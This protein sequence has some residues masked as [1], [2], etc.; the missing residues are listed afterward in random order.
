MNQDNFNIDE[1]LQQS[2]KDFA[3]E[4]PD[5]WQGIEQG[6]SQATASASSVAIQ[7]QSLFLKVMATAFATSIVSSVLFLAIKTDPYRQPLPI[8]D[9][10]KND[11]ATQV[12][13]Y[14]TIAPSAEINI[15]S[16]VETTL[17]KDFTQIVESE[18]QKINTENQNQKAQTIK[19]TESFHNHESNISQEQTLNSES[20]NKQEYIQP[21]KSSAKQDNKTHNTTTHTKQELIEEKRNSAH[22]QQNAAITEDPIFIPNVITP[23]GDGVNDN[24]VIELPLCEE[25]FIKILNRNGQIVFESDKQ[26]E[27]WNGKWKN[28]GDN[29]EPGVYVYVLKYKI[30]G[31]SSTTKNGKINLL[32]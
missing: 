28:S 14:E 21:S 17:P 24:F 31:S 22:E 15:E 29:C 3:P 18:K 6:V 30:I 11:G 12:Q 16:S 23:N 32:N 13:A 7:S 26:A 2:F 4:A 1:L 19:N 8:N 27:S 25:F 10:A 20:N 9:S 5:V